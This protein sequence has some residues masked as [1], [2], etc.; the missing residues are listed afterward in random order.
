[1]SDIFISY[2]REDRERAKALAEALEGQNW[3]VWWDRHIPPG[4]TFDEVVEEA[5]D[6]ARCVIVLWSVNSASSD[7]VKVEAAEGLRRRILVP[8]LIEAAR[9]PLEFR[10]IQAADLAD[11]GVSSPHAGF[12]D[13]VTAITTILDAGVSPTV[14]PSSRPLLPAHP[15]ALSTSSQNPQGWRGELIETGWSFRKMRIYLSLDSHLIE[16]RLTKPMGLQIVKVDD[17]VVA[18]AGGPIA[19]PG[20]YEFQVADGDQTYQATLESEQPI[21]PFKLRS[22][23]LTV[24]GRQLYNE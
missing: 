10:R 3:T 2:A 20:K 11:W 4:R 16:F 6:S 24:E 5:L 1:M 13:L 8:A 17:V 7:W 19:W 12:D 18:Q 21:W 15:L 22:C 9:I 14:G 23:R